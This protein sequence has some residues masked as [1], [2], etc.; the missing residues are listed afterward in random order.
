[1][2]RI[3]P[4]LVGLVC[5]L[6][7]Y[8]QD[9]TITGKIV[10]DANEALPGVN[11]ILKGTTVGTVSASDGTFSLVL[12]Q[13]GGTLVFSFIGLATQEVA[14][15]ESNVVN[16]TMATDVRQLS[17]VIVTGVGVATDKRKIAIS[18][19]SVSASELPQAPTASID[20]AL[21]GK[22]AGAQISSTSGTP[23]APVN[24]LLRGINTIN[25]S[26]SPM[27]LIDGVQMAATALNTIDLSTIDRV[28]VVQGAAAATI[29]G[30]QGANGVIQLFT[31]RGKAGKLTVDI[32][33]G[34]SR[35]E[36]L[37]VGNVRKADKHAFVTN[38]DNVVIGA[39]GNPLVV[40]P[41]TGAYSENVQYFSLDPTVTNSKEYDQ[42]LQYH[43]HFAL[44]FKPAYTTN[45]SVSVA[46]G[47]EKMDFSLSASNSH[48]ESNVINN[49]YW[50]RSNLTANLGTTIAKGLTLRSITNVAFTRNTLKTRDRDI[51][52][53]MMN[54]YPFADF[55]ARTTDGSIPYYLNQTIGI[56]SRNP[57]FRQEYTDNNDKKIDII[58]SFNLNYKFP[59]FV[60]LDAKYGLNYQVQDR[61][62][63]YMN[64][65][66]N[67]NVR[68]WA[69][70]NSQQFIS[71]YNTA[72]TGD[73]TKYNNS[74]TF[75][76]F[77]ASS[78]FTFDFK[79]DFNLDFPLKSSTQV[80]FDWRKNVIR[81]FTT[82]AIGLPASY[83]PY[84]AANTGSWRVYRD[85]EEP[86]V[87]YGYLVN[88]RFDYS[89]F[90]GVSGG[91]RSD[92]SSAFGQGSKP[93]TF[94]R[95]DAYFRLSALDFWE[96]G[97][98][99]NSIPE[100]K[101]R[102]AYGQAGIQPKPFDRY[103]TVNPSTIGTS[104]AFYYTHQQ[105]NSALNV[106]VSK[107]F[108]V[109]FDIVISLL[110]NTPWL[111][112]VAISPTYWDRRTDN[113]IFNVD[114]APSVGLGTIKDN[115]F[116]IGS[117]GF[118]VSLNSTVYSGSSFT[119][120]TTVNY[121]NQTSK[122][123]S[124]V[125]DQPILMT[126][127]AGSTNYILQPGLKIGQLYGNKM[128]H[129]VDARDENGNFFI[130][131]AQQANY[132][133]ASNGYV[134][135]RTTKQPF[136]TAQKYSFGDPNPKFNMSFINEFNYKSFLTVGFQFD[137]VYKSH[138]Y[139]QTKGWMFRDGISSDY[140]KTF[141]I[142]G[143]EPQAWTA[144]YRGLYAARIAN[145]TKDY[146]YEDA[147]FLRLRN[148]AVGLDFAKMFNMPVFRKLQLVLSGRNL[149]T[150][151]DY[152][153]FDPEI[154]SD[155]SAE[156]GSAWDRGTDHNTMPNFKSYQVTL[157]IG[158]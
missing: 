126:A 31:K 86:F 83:E 93:F 122:I 10:D 35:N 13:S 156:G 23:G 44:F 136:L 66:R 94:G 14:L 88:Q 34:V 90:V 25:K 79:D 37:N 57:L 58:Q 75:Q 113:S 22:V 140:T 19:S 102:A 148:V 39:S 45:N 143:E 78:T 129:A 74:T 4:L 20:Q 107:E 68:Y 105:S 42:N 81:E 89:D 115:A 103:V 106:E 84:N 12:P 131:E 147:T 55:E 29:Y 5:A 32:S 24:I 28:E 116:A 76:N 70:Q 6:T 130:P 152:T 52:F 119:W 49:G 27:V 1:M 132:A 18:V 110:R 111:N 91:F 139:N 36:Y 59:K 99:S 150:L 50:D 53:Q 134:V 38:A 109:G 98:L 7:A 135:N 112:D 9:R 26:T 158:F 71:N 65:S 48:Q 100:L 15:T 69:S 96:N 3:L 82:A 61:R 77:L 47:S 16:V 40:D 11:V 51:I 2:K 95:G 114:V 151:T 149:W 146:F 141:S 73:I 117:N 101:L 8:A 133:V 108:E 145:G 118:Q 21:V 128:L 54:A 123:L 56:N 87:T 127:A 153:G 120:N 142:D 138:L 85:Y 121:G 72:N 64:Q 46:G 43:D 67:Q 17:E 60:E 30:A 155:T 80:L 41:N 154:S 33:S 92:Y 104:P 124:V 62:L 137:W 63:E 97:S 144:F 157:N 125:G